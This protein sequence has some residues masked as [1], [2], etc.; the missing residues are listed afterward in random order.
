MQVSGHLPGCNLLH[1][2]NGFSPGLAAVH[3]E[4]TNTVYPPMTFLT[5]G[6]LGFTS[7][8]SGLAMA[9]LVC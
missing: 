6:K 5:S 4:P 9:L 2:S 7:S 3:W 1:F 8:Y